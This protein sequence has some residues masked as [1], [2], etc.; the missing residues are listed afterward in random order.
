M[1]LNLGH[2]KLTAAHFFFVFQKKKIFDYFLLKFSLHLCGYFVDIVFF[3]ELCYANN[4]HKMATG[5]VL[6]G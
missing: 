3:P 2:L 1:N 5:L 6:I 4:S